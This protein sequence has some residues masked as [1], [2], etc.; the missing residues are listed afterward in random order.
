MSLASAGYDRLAMN[1]RGPVPKA[2]SKQL[3]QRDRQTAPAALDA[4][5]NGVK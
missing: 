2:R 1:R 4:A 3:S 5:Q